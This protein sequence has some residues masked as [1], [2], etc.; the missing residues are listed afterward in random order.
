MII[1]LHKQERKIRQNK[2]INHYIL[3]LYKNYIK[4]TYY[5]LNK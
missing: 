1:K 3:F 5:I 4:I 2:E